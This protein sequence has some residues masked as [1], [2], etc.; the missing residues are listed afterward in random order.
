MPTDPGSRLTLKINNAELVCSFGAFW[1]E[2]Y[3]FLPKSVSLKNWYD[4]SLDFFNTKGVWV[5]RGALSATNIFE[6]QK[7]ELNL[8]IDGIREWPLDQIQ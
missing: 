5:D 7:A 8:D 3:D 4:L 6:Q 2:V 1:L